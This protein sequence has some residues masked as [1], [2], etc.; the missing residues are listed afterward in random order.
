M[1]SPVSTRATILTNDNRQTHFCMGFPGIGYNTPDRLTASVMSAYLGG[2]MSSVLFHRVRETS[3]LAYTV[4]TF[5]DFYR[6][7]GL[8]GVYLGTDQTHLRRAFE[9][10]MA[11]CRKLKK[12]TLSS[13]GAGQD[14]GPDSGTNHSQHG[15]KFQPDESHC[16]VRIDDGEV[17]DIPRV[18]SRD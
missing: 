8:F 7:G 3:A 1:I 17:S 18:A 14:Q 4:F 2:G 10:V 11:E 12:K 5:T 15:I 9:I 16:A 13:G 6:D